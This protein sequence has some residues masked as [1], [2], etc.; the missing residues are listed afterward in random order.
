MTFKY[1]GMILAAGFGKRMMPLTLDKPKPLITIKGITLLEN[2]INFLE[3]LGCDEIII[4]IHYKHELIQKFI[5][6]KF[7]KHNIKLIYE[8]EILDTG[9]GIKNASSFFSHKDIIVINSDIY[10]HKSNLI[11]VKL[12]IKLYSDNKNKKNTYLLLSEKKNS[13]GLN[14]SDGDFTINNLNEILRFKNGDKIIYFTGLQIFH[15]DILKKFNQKKFSVNI[16][17]DYLIDKNSLFGMVMRSD[18]YHVGDIQGLNIVRKLN[19]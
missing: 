16:I 13:H 12:L 14:K 2:S 15:L 1:S 3:F 10:W 7:N 8:N 5:S 17:W 11:D 6:K 18:W 9:G 4:N 19:Y